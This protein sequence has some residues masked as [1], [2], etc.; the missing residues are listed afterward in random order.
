LNNSAAESRK[1]Q[2]RPKTGFDILYWPV[3]GLFAAGCVLASVNS[4]TSAVPEANVG[5]LYFLLLALAVATTIVALSR[6]LPFQNVLL[7]STIIALISAA[8]HALTSFNS[9]PFGP[10]IYTGRLGPVLFHTLPITMPLLWILILLN[11]RGVARLIM[12]PWRKTRNY[13]FWVFGIAAIMVTLFDM[14]FEPFAAH[15]HQYW[16]WGPT[17]AGLYWYNAPWSNSIGWAVVAILILAFSTPSLINKK[18]VKQPIDYSPVLVWTLCHVVLL[19]AA[20]SHH[21]WPAAIL[22]AA[23]AAI[24]AGLAIRGATW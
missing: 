19:A 11:S 21:L 4:F 22:V 1:T 9:I 23:S 3:F 6:R 2:R 16:L 15:I 13:G 10:A 8:A 24:P 20:V 7:A 18:P 5:W 17:H 12:R 14:S